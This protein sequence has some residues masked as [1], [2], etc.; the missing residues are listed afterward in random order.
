MNHLIYYRRMSFRGRN[1]VP[2]ISTTL[3]LSLLFPVNPCT[4]EIA[5]IKIHFRDASELLP[6]VETLLSSEGKVFIDTRT[7]S[8]VVRDKSESLH[9]IRAF[10]AE[11]DKPAEQVRI[12]FRFLHEQLS[13]ERDIS[14]SGKIS[15]KWGSVTTGKRK[16]DGVNIHVEDKE[17]NRQRKGE[18]F[19]TVT[20]GSP[21][22]LSVGKAIP[23]TERWAYLNRRYARFV[24]VKPVVAGERVHL[25]IVPRISYEERGKKGVIHFTKASTRLT[26]FR[27][28]WTTIG[29]TSEHSNEA[30]HE[31][32]ASG[33]STESS[34]FSLSLMVEPR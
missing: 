31:I 14:M 8:I 28:Q 12:R 3:L 25:D 34:T 4:A 15:G 18:F 10:L 27:G 32:L 26:V 22:Y 19:I 29:G 21:A 11:S 1:M 13:S 6:L 16:K 33:T 20:S 7:N 9:Q 24:E 5:V 30:I 23:Y 2:F 17:K